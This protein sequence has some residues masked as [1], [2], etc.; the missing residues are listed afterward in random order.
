[1]K[2]NILLQHQKS[3]VLSQNKAYKAKNKKNQ[4]KKF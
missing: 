4:S 2:W 3:L 1:M